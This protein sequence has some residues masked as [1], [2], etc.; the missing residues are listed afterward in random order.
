MSAK[1]IIDLDKLHEDETV[2]LDS[3]LDPKKLEM[4]VED[5]HY[6]S[7]LRIHG[8][9]EKMPEVLLFKGTISANVEQLCGRC[10]EEVP[11]EVKEPFDFV[12]EIRGKT[13]LD[14]TDDMREIMI[15]SYPLKFL[16][17]EECK[18][19]CAGCGVN[20]NLEACKCKK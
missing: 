6:K 10:L 9:L 1:L 5:F 13:Q 2:E 17:K 16:C 8:S 20:L 4:E 15:I 14:V 12:F 11:S 7:Q 3:E 19:L 18:G